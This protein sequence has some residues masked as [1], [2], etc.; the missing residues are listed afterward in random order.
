[1]KNLNFLILGGEVIFSQVVVHFY[2][3]TESY[4]G[5]LSVLVYGPAMS[6]VS[7][8]ACTW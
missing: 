2:R 6:F 1:M 4:A 7:R 3:P 5:L 8:Y